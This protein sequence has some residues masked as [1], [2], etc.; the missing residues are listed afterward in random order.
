MPYD[1]LRGDL[2]HRLRSA[3]GHLRGILSMVEADADCEV[4]L[5]QMIA[6]QRALA[7][8]NRRLLASHLSDCLTAALRNPDLEARERAVAGVVTLYALLVGTGG[9]VPDE[10]GDLIRGEPR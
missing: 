2:V 4:I 10:M 1:A 7:E 9:P 3:E 6:V 8:V 5:H